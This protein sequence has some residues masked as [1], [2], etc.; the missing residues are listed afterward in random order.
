MSGA[1]RYESD[2]VFR[3]SEECKD[4]SCQDDVF[5]FVATGDVKDLITACGLPRLRQFEESIRCSY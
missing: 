2:E 1:I 5:S 3:F 4:F